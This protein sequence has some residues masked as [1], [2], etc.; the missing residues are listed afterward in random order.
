VASSKT[1]NVTA[2]G[3]LGEFVPAIPFSN[4]IGKA[5]DSTHAATILGLQ[6]ISQTEAMR[7]NV[8]VMEASGQPASVLISVFDPTGKKLL[9]FPLDLRGGEQRQL[10]SFL[11]QNK[12]TLPDGRIEVKVTGGEGKVTA[13]ASVIDNKTGDPIL[14]SGVPLGQNTFDHFVLPGVADLNTGTAA[15]RT[16]MDIFNPSSTAQFTTLTFY[17]QNNSGAPQMTS[18]TINAGEIKRFDNALQTLFG[19]SNTGGAIHVTTATPTPL[20]LTGRTFNL[21]PNGTFGQLIEGVTSANAVGKGES[22]LQILQAEDSVRARTNLGVSEVTGKPATVEVTVFL[23]DSKIAPSTQIPV[24]ANGFIQVPVIQSLGLSNVY[25]ARISLRVV[26][27]DGKI[28][29]YGSIIDQLTQDATYVQ[30]QK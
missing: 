13:Y 1:Y 2:K 29:A 10:N 22:S 25:N 15:W 9:D 14:V 7:T 6:Q 26:D 11:S 28:S 24:P 21:T 4:F 8:G 30:A 3:T 23:P 5:I 16:E 17:P 18:M 12:I 19:L 20:V 27:G